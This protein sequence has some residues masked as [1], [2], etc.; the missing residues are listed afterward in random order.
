MDATD[1]TLPE[2]DDYT[3]SDWLT[4]T[5]QLQEVAY[6]AFYDEMDPE[7]R[8]DSMLMNLF[9]MVDEISE[10][11]GECGW[12]PWAQP[13]GWINRE[14]VIKEAVDLLHFAG[15]MLTHAQCTGQE[16]TAAYKAKQMK[17]LQRQIDGYDGRKGKCATCHRE[18]EDV[19]GGK[20]GW[21]AGVFKHTAYPDL[22]FCS[23]ICAETF[24]PNKEH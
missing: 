12:K 17:N 22:E 8:A 4:S 2:T 11:G 19:L 24:N 6:G 23:L 3:F 18:L 5:R 15:N 1:L 9:A 21:Q 10:M 16:L 20:E 7:T 13:R 14:A